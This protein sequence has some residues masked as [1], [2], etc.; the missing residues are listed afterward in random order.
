MVSFLRDLPRISSTSSPRSCSWWPLFWE[1]TW[2][3]P[4]PHQLGFDL[5]DNFFERAPE[6][7][8][9]LITI[10]LSLVTFLLR[11][12]PRMSFTSSP[13]LQPWWPL[14]W[15][16]LPK[17]LSF[18]HHDIVLSCNCLRFLITEL[19]LIESIP[20]EILFISENFGSISFKIRV[21]PNTNYRFQPTLA[22][23]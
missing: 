9:H 3:W 8:L 23:L 5:G 13:Q 2:E 21:C 7:E 15:I 11:E 20:L 17:E 4:L 1:S 19:T 18:H 10:V 22:Y 14:F 12:L 6:N 16:A